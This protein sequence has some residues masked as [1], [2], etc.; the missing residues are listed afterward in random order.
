MDSQVNTSTTK[1]QQVTVDVP[2]ERVPEFHAF[3]G[4]FLARPIGPRRRGRHGHRRATHG[5][6]CSHR[7]Q[8]AERG[9]AREPAAP[10]TEI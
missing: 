3:F 2:E 5:H 1:Y 4:R 9:P 6:G 10:A 7:H 8:A